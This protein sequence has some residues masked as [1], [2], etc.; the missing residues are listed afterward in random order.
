[1]L[2]HV[3]CVAGARPSLADLHLLSAVS[4]PL[5]PVGD[6]L[7]NSAVVMMSPAYNTKD[8]QF[9]GQCQVLVS[10]GIK[11]PGAFFSEPTKQCDESYVD[12]DEDRMAL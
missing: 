9:A 5:T 8:S 12:I 2:G 10:P 4:E 11:M 1:M 6:S 3:S 7:H